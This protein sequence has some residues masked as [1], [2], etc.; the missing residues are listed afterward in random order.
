MEPR[1]PALQVDSLPAEPYSINEMDYLI[2]LGLNSTIC[3]SVDTIDQFLDMFLVLDVEFCWRGSLSVEIMFVFDCGCLPVRVVVFSSYRS[4]GVL[5][6]WNL[7]CVIFQLG[8]FR[9]IWVKPIKASDIHVV[10][11]SV[12]KLFLTANCLR[13]TKLASLFGDR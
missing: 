13:K 9:I 1:S 2:S 3:V 5:E 12:Y 4:S 7:F 8:G 10:H 6:V 11:I